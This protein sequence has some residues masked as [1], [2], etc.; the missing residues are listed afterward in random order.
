MRAR[1]SRR[2][3]TA[4]AAGCSAPPK[5]CHVGRPVVDADAFNIST[6]PAL[7]PV[8]AHEEFQAVEYLLGEAL[9]GLMTARKP[10]SYE[11]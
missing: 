3:K 10:D 4:P 2:Q 11:V 1:V 5:R 9:A 6:A 8:I 7:P